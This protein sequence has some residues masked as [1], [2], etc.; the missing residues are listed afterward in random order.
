MIYNRMKCAFV[1]FAV[2]KAFLL[3]LLIQTLFSYL[4]L[5]QSFLISV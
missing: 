4:E 2:S 5:L 1:F 3:Y